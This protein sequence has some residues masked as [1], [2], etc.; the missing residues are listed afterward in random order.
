M[1]R[2]LLVVSTF[3]IFHL[4]RFSFKQK[5]Q[6]RMIRVVLNIVFLVIISPLILAEDPCKYTTSSGTIDISSLAGTG[7]SP[8][9]KD[10]QGGGTSW[11]MFFL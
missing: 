4:L 10:I 3:F 5:H 8:R 7:G 6:R 2:L 1:M 11:S 9:Y